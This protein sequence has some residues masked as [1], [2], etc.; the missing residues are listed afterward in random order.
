MIIVSG[1]KVFPAE[2]E[3]VVVELPRVLEKNPEARLD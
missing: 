3:S 2:V 1:F